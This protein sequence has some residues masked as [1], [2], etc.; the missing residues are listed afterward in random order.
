MPDAD[1][2][3]RDLLNHLFYRLGRFPE[4][5]TLNDWYGAL[6]YT[7]RDRLMDRWIKSA[8]RYWQEELRTVCYFSAEFLIGPQL[9]MNMVD[10]GLEDTVRAVLSDLGINLDNV[11]EHEEEPGL[12]N[13]GLGRL[14]A[15]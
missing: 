9:G 5:A 3:R 7:V 2:I 13:G 10:L 6:A 12:G 15:C 8:Q 11:V 4:V 1:S 14:A